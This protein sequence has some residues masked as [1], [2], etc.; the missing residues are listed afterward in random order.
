V[1]DVFE[2]LG[3]G[4]F[5]LVRDDATPEASEGQKSVPSSPRYSNVVPVSVASNVNVSAT[6]GTGPRKR[7]NETNVGT[8]KRTVSTVVVVNHLVWGVMRGEDHVVTSFP[9]L[10]L[11]AIACG[12]RRR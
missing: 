1:P 6:W 2:R 7:R 4:P 10:E 11:A 8:S 3:Y 9:D 12:V 5:P